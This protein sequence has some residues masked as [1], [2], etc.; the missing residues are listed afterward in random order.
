MKLNR[1][2]ALL[3]AG[4][5]TLLALAG[6]QSGPSGP[7]PPTGEPRRSTSGGSVQAPGSGRPP[8]RATAE[9]LVKA[10]ETGRIPEWFSP[11]EVAAVRKIGGAK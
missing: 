11:A 3:L 10:A 4:A 2:T 5:S 9:E 1:R 6:C 8:R 7:T